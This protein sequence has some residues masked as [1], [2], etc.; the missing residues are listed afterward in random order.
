MSKMSHSDLEVF[1]LFV[2][3]CVCFLQDFLEKPAV[4][5]LLCP[6]LNYYV[7]DSDM[8]K[9]NQEQLSPPPGGCQPV[10]F[11]LLAATWWSCNTSFFKRQTLGVY[12][13]G[14]LLQT[15]FHSLQQLICSAFTKEVRCQL[16]SSSKHKPF[17][18]C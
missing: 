6:S 10:S 7:V 14:L 1:L 13:P 18:Q 16:S 17:L 3:V 15:P 8:H 11:T 9:E 4:G 2:C 5:S 12:L